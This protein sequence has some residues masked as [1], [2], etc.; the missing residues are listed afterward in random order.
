[1][2]TIINASITP[3]TG[4]VQSADASGVLQLQSDGVTGLSI[5]SGGKV[6]LPSTVLGTASAGTFEYNGQAPYFTPAGTQRGVVP[7]MQYYRLESSIVGAASTAAQSVFN[8]GCTVSS[9][10]VYRF[11]MLMALTKT[12]GTTSHTISLGFA[13]TATYNN[14]LYQANGINDVGVIPEVETTPNDSVINSASQTP[15]S[16][17]FGTATQ[18]QSYWLTGTFSVDQGGTFIPQYQLSAA[19][20]P[21]TMNPGS[22]ICIYPIGAAGS[23]TSVGTWA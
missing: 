8:V 23:N 3:T 9:G 16:I 11:E 14:I 7:G 21:Y 5:N 1:M 17:S 18:V 2:A 12:S 10:T 22:F 20:G 6:V 19:V 13:G 4:L 15:I